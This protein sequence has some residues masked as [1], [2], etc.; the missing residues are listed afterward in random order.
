MLK[1]EE[2]KLKQGN[3]IT[4]EEI[5]KI[6]NEQLILSHL[7]WVSPYVVPKVPA[8]LKIVQ[9]AGEMITLVDNIWQLTV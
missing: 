2:G 7:D 8:F 4:P 3:E 6:I 5:Q 1:I 9:K